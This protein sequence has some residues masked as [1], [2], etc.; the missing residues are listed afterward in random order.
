MIL[1][2]SGK[3]TDPIKMLKEIEA[4]LTFRLLNDKPSVPMI[5]MQQIKDDVNEC[6]L[7]NG[8]DVNFHSP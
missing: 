8:H 5:D 6:L 4:Y 7:V 3:S 2:K 1:T